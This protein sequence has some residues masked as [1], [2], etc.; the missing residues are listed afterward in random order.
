[1]VETLEK[2]PEIASE[3]IIE[4]LKKT[5]REKEKVLLALA[6]GSTPGPVY[7][8]L[9]ESS[10]KNSVPWERILFFFGDERCVPPDAP[11]SNYRMTGEMLFNRISISES[12]VY[13]IKGEN[14]DA[15]QAA[16]EYE[17]QM[18]EKLDLLLLGMGEDAHTASLFP[19]SPAIEEKERR[20]VAVEGPGQRDMRITVTPPVIAAAGSVIV[21]AKGEEKAPAVHRALTSPFNSRRMPVQLALPRTWILD[22]AAA[23]MLDRNQFG[24]K[25]L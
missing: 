1:M 5:L 21:M 25:A 2:F 17:A 22:G 6:G 10:L 24:I 4:Q 20:V 14:P 13:R 9:A 12:Q 7:S 3:R 11:D 23:S 8:K 15:E 16:E 19:C 18:P